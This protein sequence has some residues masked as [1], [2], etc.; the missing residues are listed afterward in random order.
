MSS[1]IVVEGLHDKIR[2]ESVF[3]DA[4]IIITNGS[5][6][7]EDTVELIKNLSKTNEIIIFTDP[8]SPG[9][10]IRNRVSLAVPNALHAF[11]R[12]KDAI[13]KNKKKVGI[14]HA[15]KE[16]ILESLSHLYSNQCQT[17][18]ISLTDIYELGLM[19][20][21]NSRSLRDRISEE[22][23]IGKPNAKTFLKRVNML[24]IKKEELKELCQ[25]L[26]V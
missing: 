20:M 10:K 21:Q 9:E 7:S 19:G 23:N 13:S 16:C 26:E 17:D 5:E 8:D 25:K 15:S 4:N 18:T 22:L 11:L 24:Q 2:I 6:I 14:E 1:V 12:K 3:P